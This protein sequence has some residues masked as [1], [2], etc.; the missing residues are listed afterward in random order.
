[1]KRLQLLGVAVFL[2]SSVVLAGAQ[3]EELLS[4]SVQTTL[5]RS[6]SDRAEPR[7]IFD[8]PAQ[9]EAWLSEMSERLKKRVPDEFVRRKLLTA[10]HYEATRAG[11]DPQLVLGLIHVESGFNRYAVSVVG[12]R[13]LM[14]VMPFWQRSIG[15]PEHNLFDINTGLRYGCTI[16]RH[17]LD[18]ENGDYF[19][20]LGRYNGS[21][22]KAEYPN[23]VYGAW[24]NWYDWSPAAEQRVAQR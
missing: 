6:I 17:Y 10:I 1:M 18:I 12:A 15:S 19:R 4:Q 24:K 2:C 13:G 9:A 21:L 14:Q 7:L 5:Q 20:A 16:L 3:R 11:L 8:N 23:L 22:G